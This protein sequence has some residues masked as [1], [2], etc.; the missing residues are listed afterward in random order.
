MSK[1]SLRL[2]V[3]IVLV[4]VS[5][6]LYFRVA[7]TDPVQMMAKY[8]GA[9]ARLVDDG[10]GGKIHYRDLGPRDA[11]ALLLL[12]G[13]NSSLHTWDDM[14][15]LLSDQYRVIS[16]DQHGHGLTG[17]HA[18]DDYSAKAKIDAATRVLDAVGVSTAVW[19][20]NSMGGWLTWRAAL[21]VPDRVKGMILIDASGVQGGEKQKLY[22]AAKL[23]KTWL[24][25]QLVPHITPRAIVRQSIE[26]NFVDDSKITDALVNRYWEL[27]RY[28]GNR[29]AAGFRANT[30]REP[31]MWNHIGQISVPSL[32]LWGEQ[33]TV[34]PFS[35]A[36]AFDQA[37]ADSTLISY[38]QASHLP[39]EE[40]PDQLA[41]DIRT[42]LASQVFE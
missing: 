12:H 32:I 27:I 7:D 6:F 20:G 1:L 41:K 5:S 21:A 3:L 26:A 8:G 13:S 4:T 9:S 36:K 17:P 40:L 19:V 2:F 11:P 29:R 14:A 28:P 39:N 22:L 42:W 35:Y 25:Q 30:N 10:V 37:L 38:P 33:D 15:A 23:L 16:F 34:T 31:E 18:N 24:G